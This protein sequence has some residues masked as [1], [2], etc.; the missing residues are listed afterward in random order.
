MVSDNQSSVSTEGGSPKTPLEPH[1]KNTAP[2][3]SKSSSSVPTTGVKSHPIQESPQT[4][5][6]EPVVSVVSSEHLLEKMSDDNKGVIKKD[7][8]SPIEGIKIGDSVHEDIREQRQISS[9]NKGTVGDVTKD[10]SPSP[11]TSPKTKEDN[12]HPLS[13]P[14]TKEDKSFPLSS[15]LTMEDNAHSLSS[16]NTK[17]DNTFPLSSPLTKE[18]SSKGP[19]LVDVDSYKELCDVP[20]K[21]DRVEKYV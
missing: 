21:G 1:R 17:E 20:N 12:S 16:L 15:P 10:P 9:Q 19:P 13:S 7:D 5:G 4:R 11:T 3:P 6:G 14:S 2:Q 18:S 8:C